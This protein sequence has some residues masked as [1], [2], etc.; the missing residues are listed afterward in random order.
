[1]PDLHESLADQELALTNVGLSLLQQVDF[2]VE[3]LDTLLVDVDVVILP[4]AVVL[5]EVAMFRIIVK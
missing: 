2:A 3:L 5:T 4:T 1:M